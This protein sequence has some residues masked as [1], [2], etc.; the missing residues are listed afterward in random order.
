MFSGGQEDGPHAGDHN[1]VLLRKEKATPKN[2]TALPKVPQNQV[3]NI[4]NLVE[5]LGL[6]DEILLT[7]ILLRETHD[8]QGEII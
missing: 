6:N 2:P 8:L 5:Y 4:D 1:V 7:G 3:K